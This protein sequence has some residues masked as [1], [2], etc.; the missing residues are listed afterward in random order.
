MT[1]FSA[2]HPDISIDLLPVP[3]FVILSTR[4]ADLAI[5]PV[6][7]DEVFV[8]RRFWLCCREDLRK[9]RRVTSL[10]NYLRAVGRRQPRV[11]AGRQRPDGV[12]VGA[13]RRIVYTATGHDRIGVL[14]MSRW[15]D[16]QRGQR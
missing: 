14:G 12:R 11:S 7:A 8:T 10:W 13:K 16:R 2:H 3:H 9:L 6:L 15:R 4:K 1:C 5:M